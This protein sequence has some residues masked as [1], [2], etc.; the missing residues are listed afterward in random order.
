MLLQAGDLSHWNTSGNIT[1]RE[2]GHG[3][4]KAFVTSFM[5]CTKYQEIDLAEHFDTKYLDTS[6]P[7]QV[8]NRNRQSLERKD[9][10]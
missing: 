3:T 2:G 7:I 1:V 6:P 8:R 5:D 10:M 9:S 4:E